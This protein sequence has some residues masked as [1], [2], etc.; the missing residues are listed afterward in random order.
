MKVK[1]INKT[2][3]AKMDR[4]TGTLPDDLRKD[5]QKSLIVTGGSIASMLMGDPVNDFDIYLDN[6]DV[7]AG[8]VLFYIDG[9]DD[10][11][12]AIEPNDDEPERLRIF[13]RSVGAR[14]Y[15]K[16]DEEEAYSLIYVTENAVTLSDSIQVITRF[17]GDPEKIH[18]NYDFIHA[19]NYWTY[20]DGLVLNERAL[21]SLLTKELHYSGSKYPLCSIIRTRKFIRRGFTINAGQYLKM[22]FQLNKLDLLDIDVLHD[23]L[24]GVDSAYFEAF[25][26]CLKAEKEKGNVDRFSESYLCK[27]VDEIFNKVEAEEQETDNEMPF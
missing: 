22:A 23:Q 16:P 25:I 13:V 11:D 12:V 6:K 17:I 24:T 8:L 5:V 10:E 3:K 21:A 20:K 1:T 9:I 14:K 19:T 26:K 27:L 15:E 7:L 4:W 2:I 18:E